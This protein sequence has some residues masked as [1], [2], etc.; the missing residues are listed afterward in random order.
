MGYE[1]W[2]G[3]LLKGQVPFLP[4]EGW[5]AGAAT[6]GVVAAVVSWL[7][8]AGVLARSSE[9]A[10]L[11][12]YVAEHYVSKDELALLQHDIREIKEDIKLMMR[13]GFFRK[14]G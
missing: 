12:T 6:G 11:K 2:S 9:L 3:L 10:E 5:E 13:T 4:V 1:V 8:S 14:E 7:M